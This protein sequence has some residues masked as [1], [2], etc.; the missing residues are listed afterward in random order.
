LGYAP[1]GAGYIKGMKQGP[2]DDNEVGKAAEILGTS[3]DSVG[4]R[5]RSGSMQSGKVSL[6]VE[7]TFG[8]TM[9]HQRLNLK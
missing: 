8:W 7:Y 6:R 1:F 4:M 9:T 2:S 5:V 3:V